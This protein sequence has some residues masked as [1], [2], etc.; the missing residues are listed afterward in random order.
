MA[1]SELI[2]THLRSLGSTSVR[3]REDWR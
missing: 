1:R 2:P 3:I